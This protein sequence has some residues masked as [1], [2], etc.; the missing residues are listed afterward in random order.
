MFI[1]C[2]GSSANPPGAFAESIRQS[3]VV[4]LVDPKKALTAGIGGKKSNSE[5]A[6]D[7]ISWSLGPLGKALVMPMIA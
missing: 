4:S 5:K 7:Q 2:N 1:V 3:I 6:V